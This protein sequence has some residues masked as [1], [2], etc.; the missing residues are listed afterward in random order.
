[1]KQYLKLLLAREAKEVIGKKGANLW[2]LTLVLVATFSSIAFS[3]G[4]MI[5]LR[6]KMEDPFT[7]WVSIAK[8][9]DEES[10][11][12]FRDSLF[13]DENKEKYDYR[14][15][16]MDQYTNYNIMG[17]GKFKYP[18]VRFFEHIKTP[19]VDAILAE[20]NIAKGCKVDSSLLIDNT[21]GFI[22]TLD[23]AKQLGYSE[24]DLP[25]Y[26][27]YLA[28]NEGADSLGLKLVMDEFYPVAVPVLAVVRRLPNNVDMMSANFFYEQQHVNSDVTYPFDFKH[29]ESEYLHRLTFYV[30]E[31]VGKDS[32]ESFIKKSVEDSLKAR[33]QFFDVSDDYRDL[34]SWKPGAIVKIDLG[35]ER[36][37][38][39]VFQ[40]LANVIE[41]HF[42]A[43]EVRRVHKLEYGSNHAERG[44]FLSVE[45]KSLNHI[46]EFETFAKRNKIQLEMEQVHSKENFNAVTVMAS[47]LSA[48]MVIFSIICIIMFMVNMLQGYFQK[49]KRNI[50]TFKAFGMNG[51][52]LIQVYVLILVMI[53]CSSVALSLLITWGIQG[54][55]PIIGVEKE[56]FNYL[57]L[58]NMTTYIAT[59]VIFIS[60]IF[61]VIFVM[62]RMLS[63]TP[64]DLIYDRN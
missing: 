30:S 52:E 19:L 16:L 63:Q 47:I 61:T 2:L 42:D 17:K 24:D 41:E 7:N 45:F 13:L 4:S 22:I 31:E 18:S 29:H 49:V 57:S 8:S 38:R 25:S 58:W 56:G 33:L 60:T 50:G 39:G 11:K 46:R 26:I 32:F 53:V 59:L 5:Y 3:E 6:D 55:L 48:A 15:V 21:M 10:F 37:P 64:G 20:E 40:T 35:D 27:S 23:I 51:T 14:E 44:S 36:M 34:K 12:D 28:V 54:L 43:E 9:T 1:M 62:I